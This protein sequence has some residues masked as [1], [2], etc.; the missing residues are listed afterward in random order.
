VLAR[1][2]NAETLLQ[3]IEIG[4]VQGTRSFVLDQH[5]FEEI[6]HG[7]SVS[8]SALVVVAEAIFKFQARVIS[9]DNG[10]ILMN[11]E[12]SQGTSRVSPRQT[13]EVTS[14]PLDGLSTHFID[15]DGPDRRR[16]VVSEV[17]AA[18]FSRLAQGTASPPLGNK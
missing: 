6:A 16:E 18:F 2:S 3:I 14:S 5:R 1:G 13:I 4:W 15:T 17:M 7:N 11:I 12:I 10:E 9:V 8:S